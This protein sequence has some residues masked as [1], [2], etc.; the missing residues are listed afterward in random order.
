M[1]KISTTNVIILA[2]VI[3]G[4][5]NIFLMKRHSE[6]PTNK[7]KHTGLKNNANFESIQQGEETNSALSP[8][9]RQVQNSRKNSESIFMFNGDKEEEVDGNSIILETDVENQLKLPDEKGEHHEDDIFEKQI[10]KSHSE[11][12]HPTIVE[13][14]S[15]KNQSEENKKAVEGQPEDID[16]IIDPMIRRADGGRLKDVVNV[17][18]NTTKGELKV[19]VFPQ[20]CHYT[21]LSVYHV[22]ILHYY[23]RHSLCLTLIVYPYI[24][25]K[26]LTILP[27]PA[28]SVYV[29]TLVM[30]QCRCSPVPGLG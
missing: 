19:E 15:N 10:T 4:V 23:V 5:V 17:V 11:E 2:L 3:L 16:D 9:I 14:Q 12:Q 29:C 7:E 24:L 28:H 1:A 6:I 30:G 13:K 8:I 20:V 21:C 18:C 22:C 25:S 27:Q 26:N